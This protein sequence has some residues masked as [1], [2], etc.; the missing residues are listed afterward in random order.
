MKSVEKC[1]ES[2]SFV[3]QGLSSCGRT[4]TVNLYDAEIYSQN[5][6]LLK[7]MYDR[8]IYNSLSVMLNCQNTNVQLAIQITRIK[9]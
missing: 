9:F 7:T 4:E 3:Q 6:F 8:N 2:I 1:N 5:V